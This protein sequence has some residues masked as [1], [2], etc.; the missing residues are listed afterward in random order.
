MRLYEDYA[1]LLKTRCLVAEGADFFLLLFHFHDRLGR[2]N[3]AELDQRRARS[4]F[5]YNF[6]VQL[7]HGG[8]G[9]RPAK[10]RCGGG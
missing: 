3:A 10:R 6:A 7:G 8:I 2:Y 5:E 1:Q 4:F 9:S